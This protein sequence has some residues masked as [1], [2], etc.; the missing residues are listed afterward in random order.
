[1][2]RLLVKG[3]ILD[4][5]RRRQ[6]L[7]RLRPKL[8]KLVVV[9]TYQNMDELLAAV[10]DM[11]KVFGEIGKIPYEPLQEEREEELTMGETNIDK[12]LQ[13]LNDTLVNYFGSGA[14]GRVSH[15]SKGANTIQCQL[16]KSNE[17]ITSACPK[18]VYLRPKCAKCGEGH[19]IE[20]C[21]LKC[22][23][24]SNM[25]HIEDRCL[26]KNGKGPSSSTNFLKVMVNDK[27]AT[28]VE[29]NRLCGIK[30]NIF[31]GIQMPKIKMHVQTSTFGGRTESPNNEGVD[32]G[33]LVFD[34]NI[35]SKILSHFI[36]GNFSL[37]P[38]ETILIIPRELEYLEGLVKLARRKKNPKT[39][40]A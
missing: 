31:F 13:A 28:L 18:L 7:A 33:N 23:S 35:I 14:N 25:G 36:K 21:S 6:F 11:E 40:K 37:T 9:R 8:K 24:C 38:M 27:E 2:E 29:L 39:I 30:H 1:L 20:N 10:I 4:A 22:F 32:V 12:H 15:N 34:G 5:K 3:R 16:C 17:H 26:R 19:K